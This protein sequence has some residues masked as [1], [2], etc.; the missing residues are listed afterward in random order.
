MQLLASS[1]L[2]AVILLC[3]SAFLRACKR[4]SYLSLTIQ[5]THGQRQRDSSAAVARKAL[6]AVG[7][8]TNNTTLQQYSVCCTAVNKNIFRQTDPT[9]STT[10]TTEKGRR[11][12]FRLQE[13][14]LCLVWCG[15]VLGCALMLF[16]SAWWQ[17]KINTSHICKYARRLFDEYGYAQQQ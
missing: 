7:E 16:L 6:L 3:A 1:R 9:T 11:L 4:K 10:T 17:Q 14:F 13:L 15:L 8:T 5:P 2:L 12:Q